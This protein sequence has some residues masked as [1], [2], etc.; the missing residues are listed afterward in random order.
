MSACREFQKWWRENVLIP[1]MGAMTT[2]VQA[3]REFRQTVRRE[4]SRP[5]EQFV[6]Q[7][8]QVCSSW[9]WPF[10]W[11]C[12]VVITVVRVIVWIVEVILEWVVSTICEAIAV[13]VQVL[14][15]TISIIVEF[16]VSFFVCLVTDFEGWLNAFHELHTGI[17]DLAETLANLVG[18]L[19]DA[20]LGIL[21]SLGAL[22]EN[23]TIALASAVPFFGE[24]LG[25]LL[26]GLI[27]VVFSTVR[28]AIEIV[29]DVLDHARDIAF[30]LGRLDMC[31]AATGA[32]GLGTD[33]LQGLLLGVNVP[34]RWLGGIR[35]SFYAGTLSAD[36]PDKNNLTSIIDERLM[37][38]FGDDVGGL[39]RARAR[40]RMFSRPMGL[41]IL[42][43]PW[44]FYLDSR[45]TAV[46][47]RALHNEGL[48]N[49]YTAIGGPNL[50]EG[51]T[52][53]NFAHWEVVY[54]NTGVSVTRRDI[55]T[56]LREGPLAVPPFRVYAIKNAVYERH[57]EVAR[58][59]A[60][61]I[62]LDIMWG[63]IRDY[64]VSNADEF[65][66]RYATGEQSTILTRFGRMGGGADDLCQVPALAIHRYAGEGGSTLN[67]VTSWFRPP[68]ATGPSG[69]SFRDRTPEYVFRWVL[70]HELGHYFGLGHAG[71]NGLEHIMYTNAP[72]EGL[73]PVTGGTVAEY[74][75]FSS[76][77]HFTLD[78]ARVVWDWLTTAAVSCV[79]GD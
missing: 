20:T 49:L 24:L 68:G 60:F 18:S 2:W 79:R 6:S 7:A 8:Q 13:S 69:V 14:L 44:R 27:R 41:P 67:G 46:D 5:M 35:D 26:A 73:S 58:R 4:V 63:R 61:E 55:D 42:L 40:V 59:K 51:R 34:F 32:M 37:R 17:L 38:V 15:R 30:G 50:C 64:A 16:V 52:V 57:L 21:E 66:Y 77:P 12:S 76:E 31:R 22:L 19:L 33:I 56:F 47:L 45:S 28:R 39:R 43:L 25:R 36:Q 10:N 78:D 65:P 71:H 53:N 74:I 48:L 23:I 3:C 29:R 1:V 75:F 62:G 54:G 70:I 11:L 9:P 72:E